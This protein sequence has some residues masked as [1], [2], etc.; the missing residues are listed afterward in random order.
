MRAFMMQDNPP[1]WAQTQNAG[2]VDY[3]YI[4]AG[5]TKGIHSVCTYI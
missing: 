4:E 2:A 3:D 1:L 5:M